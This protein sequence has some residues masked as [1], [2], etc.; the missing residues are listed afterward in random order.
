MV[1]LGYS[2]FFLFWS[3]L[4]WLFLVLTGDIK[5]SFLCL[6]NKITHIKTDVFFYFGWPKP[7][8]FIT[9]LR[10]YPCCWLSCGAGLCLW[11]MQ[12]SSV[13]LP[14]ALLREAFSFFLSLFQSFFLGGAVVWRGVLNILEIKIQ[15]DH[16]LCTT[17]ISPTWRAGRVT[18]C[19]VLSGHRQAVQ[20]HWMHFF[21]RSWTESSVSL[22]LTKTGA[23]GE[24][25]D[26]YGGSVSHRVHASRETES[27][28]GSTPPSPSVCF[29]LVSIWNDPVRF[30]FFSF[31]FFFAAIHYKAAYSFASLLHLLGLSFFL[32]NWLHVS[33]HRCCFFV[34][35]RPFLN[36]NVYSAALFVVVLA[37]RFQ[38][39]S[40]CQTES[41]PAPF[42]PRLGV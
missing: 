20:D 41:L 6:C 14:F 22:E 38:I 10:A 4:L 15:L 8:C 29:T 16:L 30:F 40:L 37:P 25:L 9:G 28:Q 7:M 1:Q 13:R 12:H 3:H 42:L 27:C 31:F 19:V 26:R 36:R 21:S 24:K 32:F 34:H 23:S 11:V 39:R 17:C 33:R 35:L 18:G 2:R 5:Q